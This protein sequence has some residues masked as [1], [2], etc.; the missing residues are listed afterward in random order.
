MEKRRWGVELPMNTNEPHTARERERDES[1]RKM[2]FRYRRRAS[3]SLPLVG[4]R[5]RPAACFHRRRRS[6]PPDEKQYH[7]RG[8]KRERERTMEEGWLT[9]TV[10]NCTSVPKRGRRCQYGGGVVFPAV[11][12][13]PFSEGRGRPMEEKKRTITPTTAS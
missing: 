12:L 11:S 2:S 5:G 1:A 8:K 9:F 6:A 3:A 4:C 10:K 13:S 7:A